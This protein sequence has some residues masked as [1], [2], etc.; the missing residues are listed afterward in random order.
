MIYISVNN[1]KLKIMNLEALEKI[2]EEIIK[3]ENRK[4]YTYQTKNFYSY[5]S[6][7]SSGELMIR[8]NASLKN[9]N[10][11]NIAISIDLTSKL[12]HTTTLGRDPFSDNENADIIRLNE[13][14]TDFD[15]QFDEFVEQKINECEDTLLNVE[16][17]FFD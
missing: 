9:F 12:F 14:L 5:K 17:F 6:P 11:N 10:C 3:W 13:F 7:I 1:F 4:F 2:K 15:N 16:A 8:F